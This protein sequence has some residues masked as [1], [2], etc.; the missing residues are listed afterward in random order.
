LSVV[1]PSW[2]EMRHRQLMLETARERGATHI[3]MIDA[4][5]IV[6]GNLLKLNGGYPLIRRLVADTP[7]GSCLQLPLIQ[8]RGSL[9]RYHSNGIW[10]NRWLSLAFRDNPMLSW[11]GD[12]FHSREPLFEGGRKLKPNCQNSAGVFHLWGL[13]ERR[14][15]AKHAL[16]KVTERLRWPDRSVGDIDLTYN[17][18]R[19]AKDTAAHYPGMARYREPW[20]Y[21]AVPRSWWDP[22]RGELL[23]HLEPIDLTEPWQEFETQR[24]VAEHGAATFKG[25]DLFGVA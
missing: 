20:M 22:Y 6:T 21:A 7:I 17:D 13:S 12:K 5:E 10:G 19:S 15:R 4:D 1:D 23:D 24:I 25:L 14:L 3:A 2:D 16:Y 11:S 9:D 18:W 8:L